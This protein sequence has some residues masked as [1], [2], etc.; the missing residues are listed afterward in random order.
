MGYVYEDV[1]LL[2]PTQPFVTPESIRGA[3]ELYLE[4]D[5]VGVAGVSSV[6]ESPVLMRTLDK[7]HQLT[8]LLSGSSSIRRQDM[9]KYYRVNGAVYVNSVKDILAGPV[10]FNDNPLG[11][12]MRSVEGF[13][14]D[15][16]LDRRFAD[17]ILGII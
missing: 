4:H 14:I 8:A 3:Y 16:P 7:N 5:K 1:I 17:V 15:T 6:M 10:S 9:P 2:Q 12:E 11:F 13:D